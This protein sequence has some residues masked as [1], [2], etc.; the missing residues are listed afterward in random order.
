MA[1]NPGIV[2]AF[3]QPP[4]REA[5]AGRGSLRLA[6]AGGLLLSFAPAEAET[7]ARW[8]FDAAVEPLATD[9][10]GGAA[11]G[12]LILPRGAEL[13]PGK[14]GQAFWPAR[15]RRTVG[16][17]APR[18]LHLRADAGRLD[19]VANPMDSRLNLGAHDWSI[20]C[21]LWLEA[22][23][24]D[25]GVM[26]EIGSGPPETNELVTRFSVV[27]R[28]NAF[29]LTGIGPVVPGA[30]ESVGRR[31][32]YSDPAGPPDGV[33]RWEQVTLAAAG[34]VLPR[35]RWVH[36]ALVHEAASGMLRVFLGGRLVAV[37]PAR[38]TAL[39]RGPAAYLALGCDGRRGRVL[40]GAMDE[41]RVS[42]HAVHARDLPPAETLPSPEQP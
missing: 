1:S 31:I 24:M 39:P 2:T 17:E 38:L 6:F 30:A 4:R 36:V 27:P 22:G 37:A 28:E 32:E 29:V 15:S 20:E 14:F 11:P 21:W 13:G 26:Y 9:A 42:D 33:A 16:G 35:R 40:Q 8:R 18:R 41:L 7:V 5:A 19:R 23:A 25:E 10:A 3:R 34:T 12:W